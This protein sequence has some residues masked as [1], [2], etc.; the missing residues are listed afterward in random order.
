MRRVVSVILFIIGGWILAA[1]VMM[2]WIDLRLGLGAQLA[3]LG[4]YAAFST[5]FLALG[6]WASPGN[7]FADL[8]MTIMV[9]A[10]VGV[11]LGLLMFMMLSDP[12]FKKLMPPDKPMPDLHFS[13]PFGLANVLLVAALGFAAW[14]FGRSRARAA[15]PDF[16]G[17]FG[18]G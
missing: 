1:Q 15:K 9:S 17:V 7:R 18:D 12:E 6:M 4:I 8:G 10:G 3:M 13:V 14:Y 16:E 5:P 2:G 11:G